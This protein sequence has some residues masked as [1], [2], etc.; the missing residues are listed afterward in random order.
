MLL[1]YSEDIGLKTNKGGLRH[2][3]VEPKVVDVY[4]IEN[5]EC[6]PVEIIAKYLSLI[7]KNR[8]CLSFHLHP[9]KNYSNNVWLKDKLV[10]VNKLRDTV[11]DVCK[12]ANL[13]GF[14]TNHSLR[15]TSATKMYRSNIDEQ[16]IQEITGHRSLA[17]RSYKR[18]CDNQHKI[19]TNSIFS[20]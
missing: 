13:P 19:A 12:K 16:L 6:C 1:R 3:K 7:A 8:K 5:Q 11:K 17:V 10:G 18:M 9:L 14:Y 4:P 20:K 15:S 2:T